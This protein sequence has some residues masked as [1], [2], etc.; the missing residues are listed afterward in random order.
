MVSGKTPFRLLVGSYTGSAG[1]TGIYVYETNP[2]TGEATLL[3]AVGDVVNPTFL[4]FSPDRRFVYAASENGAASVVGAYAFDAKAA[5]LQLINTATAPGADPCYLSVT[6]RHVLTADYSGGSVSVFGRK[7]DGSLTDALQVIRHTGGSVNPDRQKE[8]H[9]HQTIFTPDGKFLLVNDLGTDYVTVYRYHPDETKDILT[10]VDS[11]PVKLGGGPRHL[12]FH[13]HPKNVRTAGV[14]AEYVACVLHELD[15]TVSV[16][17]I[18]AAGRLHALH[19]ASVVRR[20]DI[21]TGAADIHFS[22]DGKFVYATNRGTANDITAFAVADDGALNFIQQIPTGGAGPR[23]FALSPDEKHLLVANQQ[24]G[25]IV[26]FERNAKT[27]LLT[28]SGKQIEADKPVCL[29][30]FESV[31]AVDGTSG[32]SAQTA[33]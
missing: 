5:R 17:A 20:D 16:I 30:F 13:P 4:A 22:S 27:G 15:G 19:E 10:P 21:R 29:L 24:T 7:G 14:A 31:A 28:A 32:A 25:N 3:S 23:N 12:A 1:G 33:Y 11:L 2:A 8:P 26:I 18:D 6:D 9:V